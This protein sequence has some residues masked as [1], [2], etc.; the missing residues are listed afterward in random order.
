ML[1]RT[2]IEWMGTES[3]YTVRRTP[4]GKSIDHA[5]K[6]RTGTTC[7][8]IIN[9]YVHVHVLTYVYQLQWY[10]IIIAVIEPIQIDKQSLFLYF[11]HWHMVY[12]WITM[13]II[14]VHTANSNFIS[15]I[16]I[17]MYIPSNL[18]YMY[19]QVVSIIE[20]ITV[21]QKNPYKYYGL[22]T[23]MYE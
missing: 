15:A 14:H 16:I 13:I 11:P 6:S 12:S 2:Y 17:C 5:G 1:T 19:R 4:P 22:G 8:S 23:L 21:R 9:T 20:P 7:I 10:T 3:V 18:P